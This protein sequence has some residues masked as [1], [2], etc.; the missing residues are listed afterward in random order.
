MA[1]ATKTDVYEPKEQLEEW[2]G[3]RPS[4]ARMCDALARR[5]RFA[6]ATP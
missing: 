1:A 2:F 4:H 5:A 3:D 6:C